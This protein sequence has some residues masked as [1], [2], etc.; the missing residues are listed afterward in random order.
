MNLEMCVLPP[1]GGE[2]IAEV[3]GSA[4]W[5]LLVETF[6]SAQDIMDNSRET[7]RWGLRRFFKWCRKTGRDIKSMTPADIVAFKSSLA[8][9][10]LTSLTIGAYMTAVRNYIDLSK[11]SKV[12]KTAEKQKR[13]Q[14]DGP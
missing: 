10:R 1:S 9:E 13:I 2:A 8:K 12:C 6:L 4:D 3:Y 14:E 5:E 7:Y 11:Y